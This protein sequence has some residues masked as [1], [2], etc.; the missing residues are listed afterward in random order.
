MIEG[1]I[2]I[3][4]LQERLTRAM[5]GELEVL[6][7]LGVGGFGAVFR[8]HDPVLERDVAIKVLDPAT[9]LSP[10]GQRKFLDEARV[11]ATVE[12]PHIVPLYRAEVRDGL[13]CLTMRL[14]PGRSLAERLATEK[15]LDPAEAARLAHEVAQALSTAHARGIVH[16]DI[17]PENILL[18][19]AGHAI[20]TDFGISLVTGRASERTSGMAIGTP[21][22]LSPEQ[23]L[24]EEVDG[25]ADIYSLG[26]VLYEMLAG[27]LPFEAP[28]TAGLLAKQILETPAPLNKLRPDLPAALVAVVSHA[29]VKSP[30]ER[31]DAKAF[32]AELALARTA[33][34][35]LSPTAVRRRRRWRRIRLFAVIGIT[36]AIVLSFAIWVIVQLLKGFSGG[37]LPSLSAR[38]QSIPPALI[39]EAR[40]DGSL[41]T[42]EILKYAFIPGDQPWNEGLLLTDSALIRRTPEGPRRHALADLN[43]NLYYNGTT[44]GLVVSDKNGGIPD[45]LYGSLSGAELGALTSAMKAIGGPT[46]ARTTSAPAAQPPRP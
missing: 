30:A 15:Q 31:P 3:A 18:D 9:G 29:M 32:A 34:A 45:T 23:A 7:V 37:A 12:H 5:R 41:R 43:L 38:D 40:A 8:A 21:Q 4:A 33:D 36:A 14:I 39:A 28:T 2:D 19:A 44:R 35:L 20:V 6:D 11:V 46:R 27:R 13:L 10:E 42:G 26:V 1:R 17:K 22:Y 16:R 24:G 25:R